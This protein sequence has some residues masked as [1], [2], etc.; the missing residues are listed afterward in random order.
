MGGVRRQRLDGREKR[1]PS[2]WNCRGNPWLRISESCSFHNPYFW[3]ITASKSGNGIGRKPICIY[4]HVGGDLY[5]EIFLKER[6][7]WSSFTHLP[8]TLIMIMISIHKIK[9][10]WNNKYLGLHMQRYII[11][12]ALMYTRYFGR[13]EKRHVTC[14]DLYNHVLEY[15]DVTACWQL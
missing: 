6:T 7:A 13:T 10:D 11:A 2:P 8:F 12:L 5:A 3:Y 9:H 14:S 15:V 1:W 4:T